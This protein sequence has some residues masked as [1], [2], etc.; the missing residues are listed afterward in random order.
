M[1]QLIKNCLL[2]FILIIASGC[3]DDND[4]TCET[5]P[6]KSVLENLIGTW[7]NEGV[8]VTFNE[9]GTGSTTGLESNFTKI[10][11]MEEFR[12]FTYGPSQ[13]E[14]Y[15]FEATWDFGPEG[16]IFSLTIRYKVNENECDKIVLIDGYEN[17]LLLTR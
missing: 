5:D 15:D 14:E 4:S 17:E 16:P 10:N 13:T 3:G 8:N 1:K 2:L 11:N 6:N 9:N 12:T 7:K